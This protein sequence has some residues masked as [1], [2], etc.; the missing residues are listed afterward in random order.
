MGTAAPEEVL[1][2]AE[3]DLEEEPLVLVDSSADFVFVEVEVEVTPEELTPALLER[4]A[5]VE[6]PAWLEPVTAPEDAPAVGVVGAS[7][8]E[9]EGITG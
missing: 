9:A 7:V 2:A 6:E 8:P 3:L 5:K 1:E 4:V